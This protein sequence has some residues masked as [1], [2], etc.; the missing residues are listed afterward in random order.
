LF[1]YAFVLTP[2]RHD[3]GISTCLGQS[4][5]FPLLRPVG[6]HPQALLSGNEV[7]SFA[8]GFATVDFISTELYD[9]LLQMSYLTSLADEYHHQ[10]PSRRRPCL[11]REIVEGRTEA[12]HRLLSLRPTQHFDL[13]SSPGSGSGSEYSYAPLG[14]Q[15]DLEEL[16]R[17]AACIYSDMVLFPM[18]WISGVKN[19]LA[20]KIHAIVESSQIYASL[21]NTNTGA[22]DEAYYRH[23][24]LLA[25]ADL[26]IW[27]LYFAT[28]GAVRSDLQPSFKGLL[29]KMLEMVYGDR[30]IREHEEGGIRFEHVRGRLEAFSWWG[31]VCDGPGREVWWRIVGEL[32]VRER[33]RELAGFRERYVKE[34]DGMVGMLG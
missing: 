21:T 10:S 30:L 4:P 9:V 8:R 27:I 23:C 24:N 1:S 33:E 13:D 14:S 28:F 5:R 26:H 34:L 22:R 6:M 7:T 2:H 15:S 32:R 17:L 18:A 29:G 11:V 3:L 19:Q 20:R 16:V 31:P 25:H 12:Q